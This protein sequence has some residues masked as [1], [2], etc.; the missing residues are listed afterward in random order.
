M[1][2]GSSNKPLSFSQAIATTQSL[3][4]KMNASKLSETEIQQEVSS[5]LGTKDAGRGFF[6]SY[7]TSDLPLADDPSTGVIEGL[8]SSPEVTTELLVKNL[9]M[10]SAMAVAHKRN[11][12]FD[13]LKG[14]QKVYRRTAKLI[15]LIKSKTIQQELQKLHYAIDT[16]NGEYADFLQRWN[17]NLEQQQ[18][19]QQ[20]ISNTIS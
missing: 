12:D 10:S 17:Y 7:L 11:N 13:S 19:I 6:V 8:K 9:A 20:A 14:S 4:E 5:I 2:D 3:M 16:G 18:A 15:Q 1:V